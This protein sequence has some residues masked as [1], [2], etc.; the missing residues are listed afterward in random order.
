MIK[1]L[2]F[3][4]GTINETIPYLKAVSE[5]MMSPVMARYFI[6]WFDVNFFSFCVPMLRI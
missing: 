1:V 6:F 2:K 5:L 3:S 4:F